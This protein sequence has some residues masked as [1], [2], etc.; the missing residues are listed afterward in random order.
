MLKEMRE[1]APQVSQSQLV[2]TGATEIRQVF[3]K[4]IIPLVIR[5]YMDGLKVAFALVIAA[6]GVAFIIAVTVQVDQAVN[7]GSN[8]TDTHF[9]CP[10]TH[11]A[12]R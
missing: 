11:R 8:P 5:T 9:S 3:D 10:I 2:Q 7:P 4:N 6:T 12:L 1:M